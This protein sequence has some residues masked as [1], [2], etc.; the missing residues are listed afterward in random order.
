MAVG[1]SIFR[2]VEEQ[3]AKSVVM[4]GRTAGK[5]GRGTNPESCNPSHSGVTILIVCELR[6]HALHIISNKSHRSLA[7]LAAWTLTIFATISSA[8]IP[9]ITEYG[10]STYTTWPWG[11][12]AGPD[13]ALWF[14]E[15]QRAN[16]GRITTAGVL[17]EYPVSNSSLGITAGPDGALWFTE[18]QGNRIGRIT[19]AGVLTE[20]PVPTPAPSPA[21][22]TAGPDGALWFTESNSYVPQING[23]GRITT[24]GVFTEYPMPTPGSAPFGIT[25]GSDGALWFT[26]TQNNKIGR[27]TTAGVFTEYPVSEPS[28]ITAGPDG[29]LWF[30]FVNGGIGSITTAGVVTVYPPTL[31][32]GEPGGITAGPDGALWFTDTLNNKIGRITTGGVLTEYPVPTFGGLLGITAGSDGALWFTE[33]LGNNIGRISATS[34]CQVSPPPSL[35]KQSGTWGTLQYD[36]LPGK[37]IAEKGCALTSLNM[38][39]NFLG[40]SWSPA[41][42]NSLLDTAAGGYT[43]R[44]SVNWGPATAATNGGSTGSPVVFSDLGGWADSN[45]NSGANLNQAIATVEQGICASPA[46]PVIVGVRS[47]NSKIYDQY[48]NGKWVNATH[49][50]LVTGEI[51]NPDG[52]KAFTINDP[53]YS[54]TII[55]TDELT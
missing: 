52:T 50:V 22:I 13:G 25:A 45:A 44:G 3:G 27:I 9:T 33:Y 30:T 35:I 28:W 55:G 23:I 31:L 51:I 49:F 15:Y 53:Y 14:T 54:T 19:T 47:Q 46:L 36:R 16:V 12:T 26:E 2:S 39:L 17:T 32:P 29:A 41:T 11:I 18:Y 24:A 42:L 6:C 8:Q 48:V 38:A 5:W 4:T 37:T 21:Y 40:Q 20:Y 7:A 1:S 10:V 34:G 43:A